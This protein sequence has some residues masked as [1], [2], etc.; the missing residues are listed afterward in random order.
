[1]YGFDIF[2]F[3]HDF[4]FFKARFFITVFQSIIQ[5]ENLANL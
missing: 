5:P 4:L 3:C 1:M 2:L